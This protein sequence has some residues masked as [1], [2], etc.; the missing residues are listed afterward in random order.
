MG[1]L[2][3]HHR[4]IT[5]RIQ[6]RE[7]YLEVIKEAGADPNS[8]A[9]SKFWTLFSFYAA[10]GSIGVVWRLDGPWWWFVIATLGAYFSGSVIAFILGKRRAKRLAMSDP[11]AFD[12]LWAEGILALKLSRS[13]ILSQ[14]SVCVS[15]DDDYKKFMARHFLLKEHEASTQGLKPAIIT[16]PDGTEEEAYVR[17]CHDHND[18]DGK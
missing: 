6:A 16:Y 7:L 1:S 17:V 8:V 3:N 12:S 2:D 13:D 10:A 15:P 9:F 14:E 11:L 18:E 5:G 4:E